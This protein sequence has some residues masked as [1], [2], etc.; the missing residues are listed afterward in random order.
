MNTRLTQQYKV[1]SAMV[2]SRAG[3][4]TQSR[5]ASSCH[6]KNVIVYTSYLERHSLQGNQGSQAR[7]GDGVPDHY[8]R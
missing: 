5:R 7:L 4:L 8:I 6:A 1:A 2:D 3:L